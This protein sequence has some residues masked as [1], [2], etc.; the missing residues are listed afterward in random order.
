MRKFLENFHEELLQKSLLREDFVRQKVKEGSFGTIEALEAKG[1]R[2]EYVQNLKNAQKNYEVVVEEL[3]FYMNLSSLAFYERFELPKLKE[4]SKQEYD[5]E[6]SIT[7]A[8]ENR[9]ELKAIQN[10]REMFALDQKYFSLLAYPKTNLSAYGLYDPIYKEGY[11]VALT[12]DFALERTAYEAKQKETIE[13]LKHASA[14]LERGK[15]SIE[16]KIRILLVE[17]KRVAQNIAI[18]KE[19]LLVLQELEQAQQHRYEIGAGTLFAINQ[20]E[21]LTLAQH[22]KLLQL[23]LEAVVIDKEIQREMEL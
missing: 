19:R 12:F 1:Q 2:L 20:R 15:K 4:K 16:S 9:S 22:K 21:L 11:K 13:S 23:K 7:T 10:S 6:S 14:L 18:A 3:S 17:S 5:L 8:I